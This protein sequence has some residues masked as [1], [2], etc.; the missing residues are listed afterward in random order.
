[1]NVFWHTS[2]V[3]SFLWISLMCFGSSVHVSATKEH[4]YWHIFF[5]WTC[6]C[7]LSLQGET[8][9]FPHP[10]RLNL[11]SGL[12]SCWHWWIFSCWC[13][14]KVFLHPSKL[15]TYCFCRFSCLHAKCFFQLDFVWDFF[16][17]QPLAE[18][19][20]GFSPMWI[21]MWQFRG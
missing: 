15:H 16:L 6:I 5:W 11:N 3:I 2:Y 9:C 20:K 12:F 19:I 8:K 21:R 17:S 7:P 1:M 18:Q 10:S 4:P 14:L 13:F